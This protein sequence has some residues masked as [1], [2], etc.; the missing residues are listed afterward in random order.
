[1]SV[2]TQ[3]APKAVVVV[4]Q[5][6]V[7]GYGANARARAKSARPVFVG[8]SARAMRVEVMDYWQVQWMERSESK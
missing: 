8:S 3:L 6:A 7:L 1:M 4:V 5:V 2:M